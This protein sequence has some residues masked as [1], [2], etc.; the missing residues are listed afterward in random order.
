MLLGRVDLS[1]KILCR[2]IL[3]LPEQIYRWLNNK[4]G[5]VI[6]RRAKRNVAISIKVAI[7][8][9]IATVILFLRNDSSLFLLK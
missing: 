8:N 9:K 5:R 3:R 6:A 1:F 4:K 2:S 7:Y